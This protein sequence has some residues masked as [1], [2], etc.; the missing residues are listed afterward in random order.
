M[1][2]WIGGYVDTDVTYKEELSCG[3]G[4]S[5]ELFI[6]DVFPV[7]FN[8]RLLEHCDRRYL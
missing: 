2:R 8:G 6:R 7:H 1:D 3:P 5:K 4:Y